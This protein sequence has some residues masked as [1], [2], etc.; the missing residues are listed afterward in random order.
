MKTSPLIIGNVYIF[1][2]LFNTKSGQF[3]IVYY[4]VALVKLCYEKKTVVIRKEK[5]NGEAI[6]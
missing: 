5:K 1:I 6:W 4:F 2:V 3:N